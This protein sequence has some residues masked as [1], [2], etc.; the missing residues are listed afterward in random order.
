MTPKGNPRDALLGPHENQKNDSRNES[1]LESRRIPTF[2][3][4][5]RQRVQ[6]A[7]CVS[8]VIRKVRQRED[9]RRARALPNV[10]RS[11]RR[12]R[13]LVL[14]QNRGVR[15]ARARART[16]AAMST[17]STIGGEGSHHHVE[18]FR[19]ELISQP[20]V[21]KNSSTSAKWGRL[22]T[23]SGGAQ[24]A[25]RQDPDVALVG[26]C[27]IRDVQAALTIA[28]RAPWHSPRSTPTPRRSDQRISRLPV[29]PAVR[30]RAQL[31]LMLEACER[32]C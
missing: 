16:L 30:G 18:D 4:A 2:A 7:G 15:P 22:P 6:A 17:R 10:V 14:R 8:S 32:R 25:L 23:A 28:G 13:G 12:P 31:A 29:A 21:V 11:S 19:S 3:S 26:E 27:A 5:S 1:E 20:S 24:V 9:V